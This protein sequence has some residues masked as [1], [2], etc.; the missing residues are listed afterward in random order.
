MT[1]PLPI[2][3]ALPEDLPGLHA[4]NVAGEPGVGAISESGLGALI[5]VAEATLVVPGS[6]APLGFLL[7][8]GPGRRYGSPNYR[9]FCDR[10]EGPEGP[11]PFLYVDRIAVAAEARGRGVGEALYGA[12]FARF[13]GRGALC[14]EV[15]TLPPNPGSMRFHQRLGFEIVG[16]QVYTKDEKAVAFLER[17][18]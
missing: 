8:L 9:W 15:N 2:R 13:S 1:D 16:T 3:D 14:C 6:T 17:R 7:M 5:G 10:H 4:L 12:A 11:R 18:L